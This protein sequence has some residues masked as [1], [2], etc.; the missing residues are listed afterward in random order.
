LNR[1]NTWYLNREGAKGAKGF[2]GF[3]PD[4]GEEIRNSNIEIRNKSEI[5]ILMTETMDRVSAV[6]G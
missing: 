3:F 4:R 6:K 2:L 5:Q 1:E